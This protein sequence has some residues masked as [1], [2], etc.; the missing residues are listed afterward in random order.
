MYGILFLYNDECGFMIAF[1]IMHRDFLMHHLCTLKTSTERNFDMKLIHISDL[2]LGKR[3]G[4]YSLHEEQRDILDKILALADDERPDAFLIAGDVYHKSVPPEESVQ[5]FDNFICELA[6]RKV[7]TFI[8]SGNHDSA[9]RIAFGGR[10]MDLSG[11]HMSPVYNGKTQP[12]TLTDVYGEVNFYML[13]FIKPLTI[14][15]FFPDVKIDSYNEALK[16]AVGA[17]KIDGSKRNVIITHQFITGASLSES[18]ELFIG[19]TENVDA[20]IFEDFDYVA[21]GHI[22]SPQNIRKNMRYCGT[23]LK[24]SRSEACQK[25]SVTIVELGEKG[26]L[27]LRTVPLIPLRDVKEYRGTFAELTD[28]AF[29]SSINTDDYVY[30]TLTD[31]SEIPEV[32][33]KL[34]KIY[35]HLLTHKYDNAKTNGTSELMSMCAVT[36]TTPE[37]LFDAFFRETN[38]NGMNPQQADYISKVIKEIWEEDIL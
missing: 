18:E 23:P 35:P 20:E 38:P 14:R 8:I 9:E 36:D 1:V 26:T 33:Y 2:H 15:K 29:Y 16:L 28:S 34:R 7:Q 11:V 22:H 10:L 24:Y 21:L 13:P 12:I 32:V 4:E 5:L 19:G 30:L 6:S 27:A 17:M 37:E 31:E 3:L 25:K